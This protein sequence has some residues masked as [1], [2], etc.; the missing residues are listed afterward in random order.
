M[1]VFLN[2]DGLR[3][4]TGNDGEGGTFI[5][6]THSIADITGL[7]SKLNAKADMTTVS[8]NSNAILSL[9]QQ[10]GITD[11]KVTNNADAILSLQRLVDTKAN[12]NHKHS[13]DD[14]DNLQTALDAKVNKI[15]VGEYTLN[16]INDMWVQ[17]LASV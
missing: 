13:I 4:T 1:S 3:N 17:A 2:L 5:A 11:V 10:L 7:Q 15:D 12:T 16:D 14:V 8:N 9:Q 6:H